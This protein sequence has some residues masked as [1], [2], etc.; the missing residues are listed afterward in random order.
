MREGE[1]GYEFQ[2]LGFIL[3]MDT[4]QSGVWDFENFLMIIWIFQI[5]RNF[6]VL[7]LI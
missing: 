1:L 3:E 4:S 6:M 2:E 7:Y 5:M